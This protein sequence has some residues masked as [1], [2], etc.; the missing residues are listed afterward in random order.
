MNV[1]R[2][3]SAIFAMSFLV[4]SSIASADIIVDT[5][6]DLTPSGGFWVGSLDLGLG[7]DIPGE[8]PDGLDTFV[9]AQTFTVFRDYLNVTG[10][11][12]LSTFPGNPPF[13][14]TT[15]N[16][17]LAT[18]D[19]GTPGLPLSS[20][21]LTVTS[22]QEASASTYDLPF[23]NVDLLDGLTYWLVASSSSI[24]YTDRP[25]GSENGE[26]PVWQTVDETGDLAFGGLA[27]S[28]NSSPWVHQSN[29][30]AFAMYGTEVGNPVDNGDPRPSSPYLPT[31][32]VP[33]PTTL[34][35][36]GIGLAGMGLSRRRK[37]V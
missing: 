13:P 3:H 37:K 19:E 1:L 8:G 4:H 6:L 32:R 18:D 35:L 2:L 23:L 16:F 25:P 14:S 11:V 7:P 30:F 9:V 24:F 34:S 26:I 20:L 27:Y 29:S 10:A 28:Q 33:E 21:D 5:L 12:S 15:V 31:V 17:L 36:L 22:S